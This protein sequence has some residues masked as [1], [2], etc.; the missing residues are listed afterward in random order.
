M[1][2]EAGNMEHFKEVFQVNG[3][4]AGLAASAAVIM[5]ISVLV[6]TAVIQKIVKDENYEL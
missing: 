1:L 4:D 6:I 5:T 3:V 2:L